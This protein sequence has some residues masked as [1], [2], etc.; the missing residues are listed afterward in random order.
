MK[1]AQVLQK[2][3]AEY[4]E[5]SQIIHI[6]IGEIKIFDVIDHLFKSCAD[7]ISVIT[8]ILTEENV[9]DDLLLLPLGIIALH[10]G[11]FIQIGEQGQILCSH[12]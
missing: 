3:F 8:R 11:Q 1:T 5:T 10:H 4:A 7:R 2:I 6:F 12:T 9:K